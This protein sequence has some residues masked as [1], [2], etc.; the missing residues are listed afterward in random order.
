[1]INLFNNTNIIHSGII[2][3]PEF[4]NIRE[5]YFNDLLKIENFYKDRVYSVK[6]NNFLVRLLTNLIAPMNY[7]V[8]RYVTVVSARAPFVAN[9][10]KMT[11]NLNKGIFHNGE[12][13]G[14]GTLEVIINDTEY[15]NPF[16]AEKNWRNISAV[17]VLN[18]P[19]SDLNLLL[20]NGKAFSTG[21]GI[22]FISINIPLLAVQYRSFCLDQKN[23]MSTKDSLLGLTHFIH[24]YVLPSMI[25]GQTDIVILNRMMNLFYGAPMSQPLFKHP[26]IIHNY[27]NKLDKVLDK[28]LLNMDGKLLRYENMLQYI[29]GIA[30]DNMEE[31]LELPD[32][33]PTIQVH[34]ALILSRLNVMK[35]LIDL[36][37]EKN[38]HL[39]RDSINYLQKIL[40]ALNNNKVFD[41]NLPKSILFD[42]K[43]TV[44]DILKI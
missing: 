34:W 4:E 39:N 24:M 31:A 30:E 40:F 35:F 20:P 11:S 6:G 14:K 44:T 13:Y 1:M 37:G 8:D 26:F 17:R 33:V 18:H 38:I 15:F 27:G 5:V 32:I 36:G 25:Y 41:T 23:R 7:T 10:M 42:V 2:R 12:F 21:E 43:E 19:K 28:I 9:G 22:A 16:V 3:P 29:P